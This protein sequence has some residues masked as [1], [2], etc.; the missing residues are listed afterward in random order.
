VLRKA[1]VRSADAD[2]DAP[3]LARVAAR[4]SRAFAQLVERH[5]QRAYALAWRI[6]G[7]PADAED[8]VQEAFMK[9]W[10]G[11]ARFDATRGRFS[12]WF[13]RIVTNQALDGRRHM[14][15]VAELEEAADVVD[16]APSPEAIAQGRDVHAALA[17][18]PPRQ[19]AALAL[20]YMEGY[21]MAEVAQILDSNEKA[22]ESLLS[23]GRAALRALWQD[24]AT[25]AA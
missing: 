20:F 10:T 13:A 25:G 6:L 16:Q 19:R 4:D 21:S 1:S 11:A 15:P 17:E 2:V 12:G 3:L 23:R 5:H 9:L 7:R 18:L 22:V 24:P 14:K 8:V